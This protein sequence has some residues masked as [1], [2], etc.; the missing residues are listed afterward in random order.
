MPGRAA[1]EVGAS[2]VRAVSVA[3]YARA[4]TFPGLVAPARFVH[5]SRSDSVRDSTGGEG[6]Q[7]KVG[8][9]GLGARLTGASGGPALSG[10]RPCVPEFG[11]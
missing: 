10:E 2:A 3:A 1:A 6:N 7:E 11:L 4:G 8:S 9:C 5:F